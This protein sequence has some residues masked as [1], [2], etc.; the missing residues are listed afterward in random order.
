MTVDISC[1]NLKGTIP[2]LPIRLISMS[3]LTL[4]SNQ[5]EG[6]I[7]PFLRG[8]KFLDLS[9]NKFSDSLLFFC[10]NG[11]VEILDQLILSN[12][13]LSGS[14]PDCLSHFK[15]LAY[16]DLSHNKF[17][18][19]IPTSMGSPHELLALILRNNSLTEEIPISLRSCKVINARCE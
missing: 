13:Q 8:A 10:A 2:N 14:I 3:T 4:S 5:F 11:T 9:N 12:N 6:S 16:L 7:P 18:G 17:A 15:S 19:K 1:N